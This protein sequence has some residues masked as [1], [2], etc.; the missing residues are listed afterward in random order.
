MSDLVMLPVR[1][2]PP[3]FTISAPFG[4][5][6]EPHPHRGIDF[7]CPIGTP[8]AA[9]IDG[10]VFRAGWERDPSMEA[11]YQN[12][13][14]GLRVWQKFEI[15]ERKFF[16]WYG[17]LSQIYVEENQK[18]KAG[19]I[20]GLSG[21]TGRTTSTKHKGP[22][23]HLHVQVREQDTNNFFNIDWMKEVS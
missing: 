14:F 4:E 18:V 13:G 10:I 17:H 23:P 12:V 1:P 21:A 16:A 15:S 9:M 20:I 6:R 22:A 11:N 8:V 3:E 2:L 5:P 19:D 7:A